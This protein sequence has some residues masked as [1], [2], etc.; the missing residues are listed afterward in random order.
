MEIDFKEKD[1][2]NKIVAFLKN[3]VARVNTIKA[4]SIL[5]ALTDN[6][7]ALLISNNQYLLDIKE[8][9][10][11]SIGKI[12]ECLKVYVGLKELL[13]EIKD[14]DD[15]ELLIDIIYK[16]IG[17]KAVDKIREY[18][19]CVCEVDID[20][21]IADKIALSLGFKADDKNRIKQLIMC[22]INKDIE[23]NGNLFSHRE[24]LNKNVLEFINKADTFSCSFDNID[25][26][27]DNALNSLIIDGKVVVEENCIY[28]EDYYGIE[29][30]IVERIKASLKMN[31]FCDDKDNA[32]RHEA[33][34]HYKLN[35]E[36]E[37]AVS[38]ALTSPITVITGGPGTGKTATI[39]VL[40]SVIHA[41]NPNAEIKI[42]APTGKA[43]IKVFKATGHEATTIHKLLNLT[44]GDSKKNKINTINADFLILDEA[45]MIDA[46]LFC[47]LLTNTNPKTNIVI[48]GDH[49][50]LASVGPGAILKD[51][52][53]SGKI[54]V[55]KLKEV[56][57]QKE[58]EASLIVKN[59]HRLL[60]G[61]KTE[62]EFN[63]KEFV[64]IEEK[65]EKIIDKVIEYINLLT[66]RE[67]CPIEDIMVLSTVND[68][69]FGIKEI[70]KRI[71]NWCYD[72]AEEEECK[73]QQHDKVIQVKNNYQLD[74]MN[75]EL[76]IV[77]EYT[78]DED[79]GEIDFEVKYDDKII[80]YNNKNM[81]QLQLAYC[82]SIHKSQGSEFPIVLMPITDKNM[83]MANVNTLYTGITRA[84]NKIILI[85]NKQ[86]FFEGINRRVD[87]KRNSRIVERLNM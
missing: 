42:S 28:R 18:P 64:F 27:F 25:N 72:Q 22:V 86:A 43:A 84:K 36:Q 47:E 77:W 57:R 7:L 49:Q 56:Y 62:I 66:L 79:S 5:K 23:K 78:D 8:I 48:I 12:Q 70:N 71:H 1:T 30:N 63:N 20:F 58:G 37:E 81:D 76:G 59:A 53:S 38:T 32:L 51:L 14:L 83:Y 82:I 61:D 10:D 40:L 6:S 80:K 24:I 75:G 13:Q 45:S 3:N 85:G 44:V 29:K 55:V 26:L 74:V 50:Q 21:I 67:K 60:N 52:I 31:A 87:G 2:K 65:E 46:Y 41:I 69:E 4:E 35:A 54:P 34:I 33:L 73:I 17:G 15:V 39:R 19:Y 9:S 68:G 11:K 16:G